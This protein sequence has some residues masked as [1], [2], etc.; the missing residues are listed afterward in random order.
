[1]KTIFEILR[2][3]TS[4]NIISIKQYNDGVPVFIVYRIVWETKNHYILQI[5]STEDQAKNSIKD[6]PSEEFFIKKY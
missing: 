4:K 1:M 2:E 3:A 6:K 5:C